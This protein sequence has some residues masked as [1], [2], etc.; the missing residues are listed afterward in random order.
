MIH[1][2]TELRQ[3][4]PEVGYGVFATTF[5][6]KG[7]IVYIKDELEL[8]FKPDDPRRNDPLY[9]DIIEKYSYMEPN[10]NMVLSWDIARFVNH[11]CNCNIISTG[12]GFEIA[13]RDIHP[14]EEITD[15]YGLFNSG[16]EMNLVCSVPGCRGKLAPNDI[17]DN[18]KKW[19]AQIK[20]SFEN[21]NKISQPLLKY[22][23]E[24]TYLKLKNYLDTGKEYVSVKH[25][26]QKMAV[27]L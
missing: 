3:V 16:W 11:C 1:P 6:P 15:E 23:R 8:V 17:D 4:S 7:T 5:I 24:K 12:Y 2:E 20:S 10:G 27:K 18:Y 14:G 26:K 13:I 25:L 22:M 19:D 9:K 21:F